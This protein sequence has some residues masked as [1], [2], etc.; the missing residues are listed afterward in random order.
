MT[1]GRAV[2]LALVAAAVIGYT[3]YEALARSTSWADRAARIDGIVN[4]RRTAPAMLTRNHVL[5]PVEYSVAPPV[6]GDHPLTWQRCMGDVYEAPVAD[7]H[8]V[9]S[10]EHGAVWLTY[11]PDLPR[12]Q[13]E[14]LANRVRGRSHLM[15]SPYPGLAAPISVQA[16]GFQ[17]RVTSADDPRIE[18]FIVTLSGNGLEFGAVCTG[19]TTET[20]PR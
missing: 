9:H 10:L 14:R 8:A 3:G 11:R 4:Y 2:A 19:G 6:G 16:W 15:L 5:G 13:I 1:V 18:E 20:K 12:D 17:L 7:E